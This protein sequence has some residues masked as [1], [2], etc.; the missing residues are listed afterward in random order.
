MD[1]LKG[2][3]EKERERFD[4]YEQLTRCGSDS[5]ASE[6]AAQYA[7]RLELAPYK[8][9][10]L[11]SFAVDE[12][13]RAGEELTRFS[14]QEF[15]FEFYEIRDEIQRL[16]SEFAQAT[17]VKRLPQDPDGILAM[18]ALIRDRQIDGYEVPS[19]L[20]KVLPPT[21]RVDGKYY[22]K[23]EHPEIYPIL[24]RDFIRLDPDNGGTPGLDKIIQLFGRFK[25]LVDMMNTVHGET[26]GNQADSDL[27]QLTLEE[28]CGGSES[29][30]YLALREW[31]VSEGLCH[32]DT[33]AFRGKRKGGPSD[34]AYYLKDLANKN[35]TRDL[36]Q[37]EMVAIAR[38][39]FQF[40]ISE[41][42][43]RSDRSKPNP[44]LPQLPFFKG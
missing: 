23:I 27:H 4:F 26:Y 22:W 19:S 38:N 2:L 42:L 14:M 12:L 25:W 16:K 35:Y 32:P 33:F 13:I 10:D 9:K 5:V 20:K 28:V 30:Q 36:R 34:L 11:K 6:L 21:F 41:G 8:Y 31:F 18:D 43:L 15:E 17:V 40:K 1:W 29:A 24:L 3:S 39:S 7:T 37:K 44:L